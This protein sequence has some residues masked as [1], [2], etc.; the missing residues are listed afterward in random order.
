MRQC[1]AK[2]G[3]SHIEGSDFSFVFY[4]GKILSHFA[5]ADDGPEE[6]IS[7]I[8]VCR[9]SA[10][11]MDL[12]T[13]PSDPSDDV[14]HTKAR[15]RDEAT[16]D[17]HHRAA[18]FSV[19]REIENDVDLSVFR[20]AVA[21]VLK[22]DCEKLSTLVLKGNARYPDEI[23]AHLNLGEDSATQTERQSVACRGC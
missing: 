10:V 12:D 5:F 1:A 15:V 11:V 8:R 2:S 14:R 7:L 13:D 3:L 9:F 16:K 23:V 17:P 22:V 19:G 4:G 21:A 18:V 20:N 6:L